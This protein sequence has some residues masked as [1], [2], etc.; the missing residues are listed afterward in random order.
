MKRIC[1]VG[2]MIAMILCTQPAQAAAAPA[3]S[4]ASAI[5]VD[6]DTGRVLFEE[7][8]HDRRLIASITNYLTSD[9]EVLV[10]PWREERDWRLILMDT[11]G[12]IMH[13]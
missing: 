11:D 7:N 5:L 10:P 4:A 6:G 13:M 12:L 1:A 2:F 8:A 9:L 3:L